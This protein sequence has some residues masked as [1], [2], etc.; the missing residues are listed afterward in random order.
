MKLFKTLA[1]IFF[2]LLPA[3]AF[4]PLGVGCDGDSI[5]TVRFVLGNG[6]AD[7]V[8]NVSGGKVVMP[9]I[10]IKNGY[11]FNGW[12]YSVDEGITFAGE[13]INEKI[14]ADTTVYAYWYAGAVLP[15]LAPGMYDAA[16]NLRFKSGGRPV[17]YTLDGSDPIM[18]KTSGGV[19]IETGSTKVFSEEAPILIRNR[20]TERPRL[21]E[22]T[23][24]MWNNKLEVGAYTG[25]P[26]NYNRGTVVKAA[27]LNTNGT[28]SNIWTGTYIVWPGYKEEFDLPVMSI[29]LPAPQLFA[30]KG[31]NNPLAP[32]GGIYRYEGDDIEYVATFEYFDKNKNLVF[33]RDGGLK[34]SSGKYAGGAPMKTFNVNLNRGNYNA[35]VNYPMWGNFKRG[36]KDE[37]VTSF[38]RFRLRNGGQSYAYGGYNQVLAQSLAECLN[39]ANASAVF[40]AVYLNGDFWG[41]YS[42][43]EHY[44]DRYLS[45]HYNETNRS[46]M[47]LIEFGSNCNNVPEVSSGT[48]A[49]VRLYQ[50]MYDFA[51]NNDFTDNTVYQE[52]ERKYMDL[53]DYTD[54]VL[55]HIFFNN[56]DFPGN[57]NRMWRAET[58]RNGNNTYLDGRWHQ[59]LYDFDSA[60]D[61]S[62]NPEQDMLAHFLGERMVND[63]IAKLNPGWATLFFRRLMS[64]AEYRARLLDRAVYFY[65]YVLEPDRVAEHVDKWYYQLKSLQPFQSSRWMLS[66]DLEK[67]RDDYK[68]FI[69]TRRDL[70]M[71]HF[72]EHYSPNDHTAFIT[73]NGDADFDGE[74]NDKTCA[75]GVFVVPTSIDF[76]TTA[77]GRTDETAIKWTYAG[78]E[79][80]ETL[81]GFVDAAATK[82][83]TL[84]SGMQICLENQNAD[85]SCYEISLDNGVTVQTVTDS[86]YTFMVGMSKISVKILY[87]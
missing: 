75:G 15:S 5:S 78:A 87:K 72:S 20:T 16:Q 82:R 43:E 4:V 85:F 45:T 80:N 74:K 64:N 33:F 18:L 63:E 67:V 26:P 59:M 7:I 13:F 36:A 48:D 39:P 25:S 49:A 61:Y 55:S 54:V 38:T 3:F 66:V 28:L 58:P 29:A 52:F 22:S 70:V 23:I 2:A 9:E 73:L 31:D 77:V 1:F 76:S 40:T 30:K 86:K 79:F 6:S 46:N 37:P 53:D 47:M 34:V 83:L 50:E 21:A 42:L 17:F 60:F 84:F 12:F 68:V 57:N 24:G 32:D 27:V 65:N 44:D 41:I 11:T 51:K 69:A 10:P 71:Q 56:S 62:Q 35:V 14:T 8:K 19:Y 81:S